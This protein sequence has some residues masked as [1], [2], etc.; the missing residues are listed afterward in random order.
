MSLRTD[1][2]REYK[3]WEAMRTRCRNPRNHLWPRYGGR[4]I[5]VCDRWESFSYFLA[6]MGP[7]PNG[8]SLDRIDNDGP[9]SP[10]NCRWATPEQQRANQRPRT[11]ARTCKRGHPLP[12]N[13]RNRCMV[14]LRANERARYAA[15]QNQ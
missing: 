7:R 14:C 12:A 15:R 5:T 10:E 8:T 9:Y 2:P 13:G 1:H 11:L 4:G 3:S 6:D